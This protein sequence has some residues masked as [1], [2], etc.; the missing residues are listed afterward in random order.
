M[1]NRHLIRLDTDNLYILDRLREVDESYYLVYNLD[2]KCYEVHSDEQRGESYCFTSPFSVL[3]ER[4]VQYARKTRVARQDEIIKE[5]DQ[6]N[7]RRENR[8]YKDAVEKI[9][10]VLE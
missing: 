5:I 8:I 4:I 10:E 9:K 6:A 7:E 1:N 3:D 2:R